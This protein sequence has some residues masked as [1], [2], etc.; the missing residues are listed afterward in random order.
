M[1]T[2][3]KNLLPIDDKIPLELKGLV[4][5]RGS[6]IFNPDRKRLQCQLKV[7]H[8]FYKKF[9]RVLENIGI[10]RGRTLG[11]MVVIHSKE[12][13]KRQRWHYDYDPDLVKKSRKKPCGVLLALEE[14]TTLSIYGEGDVSLN[15]GDCLVFDGDLVHA[16]SAYERA[17]TRVHM[18]LDVPTLTRQANRTWYYWVAIYD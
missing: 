3:Y 15:I 1:Y 9:A 17:N 2:I 7:S 8:P 6:F 14:G 5:N 18:F 10:V 11:P 16:G 13:C 4:L 12:G